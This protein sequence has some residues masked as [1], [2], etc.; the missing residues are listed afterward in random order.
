MNLT[1][2][3]RFSVLFTALVL[4]PGCTATRH[5]TTA[6]SADGVKI[7]FDAT[8]EGEPALV[9]VHGW[10]N[11]RTIWDAQ[12]AHFSQNHEVIALDLP[13]FGESGDGRADWSTAAF[14]EDIERV[15]KAVGAER[16]VLVGF[17]MGGPV[18]VEAARRMPDRV[19][20][21]V[22]VDT[23]KDPDQRIPDAVVQVRDSIMMDVVTHPTV[24]KTQYFF[25]RN[26]DAS[27]QRVLAMLAGG[28][29]PGWR[30]SLDATMHWMNEDCASAL[31]ALRV[32][33]VAINSAQEPTNVEAM[34]KYVPSFEA[35][36]IPDVGHVLM[37]E[38]PEEF[39]RL[40]EESIAG[41]GS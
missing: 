27:Y 40:L 21:I 9:L 8:G 18:V 11:N 15:V 12:V 14:G 17:S 13:G 32:P 10:S 24:E 1:T 25:R 29:R 19:A 23:I 7:A 26:V 2:T 41:F 30:P 39:N 33:V 38:A 16:V 31:Q 28:P 5:D 37:W 6:T 34:R 36:I 4:V 3:L 20:G 35:R 22:L